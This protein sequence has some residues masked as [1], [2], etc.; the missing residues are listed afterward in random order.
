MATFR[1]AA[2]RLA[3]VMMVLFLLMCRPMGLRADQAHEVG[4]MENN[5]ELTAQRAELQRLVD[6]LRGAM[7]A[8]QGAGRDLLGTTPTAGGLATGFASSLGKGLSSLGGGNIASLLGTARQ[9]TTFQPDLASLVSGFSTMTNPFGSGGPNLLG[10]PGLLQNI[11][12]DPLLQGIIN[13]DPLSGILGGPVPPL[14]PNLEAALNGSSADPV[15]I[16]TL[17]L[18]SGIMN[19][20]SSILYTVSGGL[21][22]AAASLGLIPASLGTITGPLGFGLSSA[23]FGLTL[24]QDTTVDAAVQRWQLVVNQLADRLGELNNGT[25]LGSIRGYQGQL[26]RASGLLQSVQNRFNPTSSS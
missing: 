16:A 10:L 12:T 26:G 24:S 22:T 9:S 19:L 4:E 11:G 17:G 15:A 18:L 5:P 20:V 23:S 6:E 14:D 7:P 21:G 13:G 8:E 3:P 25:I 1:D 2:P